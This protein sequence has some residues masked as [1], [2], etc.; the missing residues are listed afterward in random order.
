MDKL[1]IAAGLIFGTAVWFL[2]FVILGIGLG[3]AFIAGGCVLAATVIAAAMLFATVDAPITAAGMTLGIAT[4]IVMAV[5]LS[6]PLWVDIVSGAGV[7]ALYGIVDGM[8]RRSRPVGEPEPATV[9][10]RTFG[11]AYAT[12]ANGH[13]HASREPVGAR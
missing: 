13:S 12:K 9:H 6:V 11:G 10:D 4:F 3:T 1:L 2:L 8:V 5:V 7:T